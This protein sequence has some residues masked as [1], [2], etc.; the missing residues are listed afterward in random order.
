[1]PESVFTVQIPDEKV[2]MSEADSH[3]I[4]ELALGFD[5]GV[6]DWAHDPAKVE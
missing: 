3:K 6:P 1:M 4:K 5:I 2:V